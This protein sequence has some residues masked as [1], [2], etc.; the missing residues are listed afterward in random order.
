MLILILLREAARVLSDDIVRTYE[1]VI[2]KSPDD[3]RMLKWP[4]QLETLRLAPGKSCVQ[5]QEQA[6]LLAHP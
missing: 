4:I 5:S 6:T 1:E 2:S 3:C